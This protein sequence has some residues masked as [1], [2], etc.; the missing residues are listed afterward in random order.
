[1]ATVRYF[2]GGRDSRK[3]SAA[4]EL[5]RLEIDKKGKLQPGE[6]YKILLKKKLAAAR[7]QA[8][9]KQA[10]GRNMSKKAEQ[11]IKEIAAK[12]AAKEAKALRRMVIVQP[13]IYHNG[14]INAKGKVT[15]I[16][17]NIVAQVNLKNG[18]MATAGGWSLGKYKPASMRTHQAL[19]EAIDKYSPY[20]IKQRQMQMAQQAALLNGGHDEVINLYGANTPNTQ[21]A[22]QALNLFGEAAS[23]PRQNIGV[24]AWGAMA[25]NPWG[26]FADNAWGTTSD[27]VWGTA[28]TNVWGGIGGNAFGGKGIQFFGTGN[29]TNYLKS[30]TSI[31]KAYFGFSSKSG[32]DAFKAVVKAR[33]AGGGSSGRNATARAAVGRTG[34]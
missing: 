6:R 9:L 19:M 8:M 21:Q 33:Q 18:K 26:T 4:A 7:E 12:K 31:I 17:G 27:N 13:K 24:T 20:Y 29:G 25:D 30:L 5:M 16:E 34:R 23:G 11:A 15:D 2:G 14:K 28:S 22:P 10:G 32:K 1:M 3:R